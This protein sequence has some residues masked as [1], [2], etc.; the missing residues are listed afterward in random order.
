MHTGTKW[1]HCATYDTGNAAMQSYIKTHEAIL[2]CPVVPEV[3][4][5]DNIVMGWPF[6]YNMLGRF[7]VSWCS[8]W[9]LLTMVHT[10]VN[11]AMW[12]CMCWAVSNDV[13]TYQTIVCTEWA[14]Y[15]T[16]SCQWARLL[17][18]FSNLWL[19]KVIWLTIEW[20]I[21]PLMMLWQLCSYVALE[22]L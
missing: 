5:C 7:G 1:V 8:L 11:A 16:L 9:T 18:R 15:D 19:A 13:V 20:S 3:F 6:A 2:E 21:L 10:Y 12:R 14:S 17:N 22:G 4:C